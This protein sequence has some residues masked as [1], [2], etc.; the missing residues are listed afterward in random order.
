LAVV[1]HPAKAK[2]VTSAPAKANT[3]FLPII[4][5]SPILERSPSARAAWASYPCAGS[6]GP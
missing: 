4:V 5:V 2:L 1:W 6:C 3:G